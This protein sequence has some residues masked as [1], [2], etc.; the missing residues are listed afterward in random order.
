MFLLLGNRTDHH[1]H[2]LS[3]QLG[4]PLHLAVVFEFY[5]KP[6]Q[7]LLSLLGEEYRTPPE[8]HISL[9][10]AAFL[11]EV[12]G[13]LELELEVVLVGL[14]SE[15]YLLY[16]HLRCI[17]LLHLGLLAL[18]ILELLIVNNLANGGIGVGRNLDQIQFLSFSHV[19]SFP[20]RVDALFNIISH[21]AHLG[22]G[23]FLIDAVP[24]LVLRITLGVGIFLLRC[25]FGPRW[26][27]VGS[28]YIGILLIKLLVN[29]VLYQFHKFFNLHSAD[30]DSTL[31][32]N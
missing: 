14:G 2:P 10:L 24:V 32:A 5:R 9:D 29:L 21:Y 20:Q 4:Q 13:V 17:C 28:C 19:Q 12:D 1:D 27:I 25:G 30:V 8:E 6:E 23:D 15:T 18:L 16:H 11:E 7:K 31:L 3:F 26:P 22:C